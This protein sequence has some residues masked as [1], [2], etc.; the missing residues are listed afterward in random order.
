LKHATHGKFLCQTPHCRRF[1]PNL[2]TPRIV[3]DNKQSFEIA[4]Y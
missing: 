1:W 4:K 2:E 3:C